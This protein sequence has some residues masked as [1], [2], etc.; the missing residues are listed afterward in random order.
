MP[1]K[2]QF[3]DDQNRVIKEMVENQYTLTEITDAL[4]KSGLKISPATLST[5][6]KKLGIDKIDCR[7][8]NGDP[9]GD[10]NIKDFIQSKE[11]IPSR[12]KM[13]KYSDDEVLSID[14]IK[15]IGIDEDGNPLFFKV[16]IGRNRKIETVECLVTEEMIKGSECRS[17]SRKWWTLERMRFDFGQ[18]NRALIPGQK[19]GDWRGVER[20]F[21]FDGD[22][23][24][25]YDDVDIIKEHQ[26]AWERYVDARFNYKKQRTYRTQFEID[27]NNIFIFN[28]LNNSQI[29]DIIKSS[30]EFVFKYIP[31]YLYGAI[32]DWCL[33]KME[34]DMRILGTTSKQL[35][36]IRRTMN[37]TK[38]ETDGYYASKITLDLIKRYLSNHPNDYKDVIQHCVMNAIDKQLLDRRYVHTLVDIVTNIKFKSVDVVGLNGVGDLDWFAENGI[39]TKMISNEEEVKERY[40]FV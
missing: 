40:G 27:S 19:K 29:D 31:S 21:D 8:W 35:N 3:T 24:Y 14:D 7:R 32:V 38:V 9:R 26:D 5:Y 2:I 23:C 4:L 6:I 17:E 30:P 12:Y 34:D 33:T 16:G 37:N 10:N 22:G 36:I 15:K 13:N 20:R 25:R 11:R 39:L 18:R 1:K 28:Q